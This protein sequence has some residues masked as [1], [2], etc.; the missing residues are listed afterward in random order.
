[1]ERKL[2]VIGR[3][4]IFSVTLFAL[5]VFVAAVN[6]GD[7]L[8][9]LTVV[10]LLGVAWAGGVR[11]I[12]FIFGSESGALDMESFEKYMVGRGKEIPATNRVM[13][14]DNRNLVGAAMSTVR[15]SQTRD[16]NSQDK[17]DRAWVEMT[18]VL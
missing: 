16:T 1:M 11:V 6:N 9:F 10:P 13:G 7:I 3:L 17:E 12:F 15:E 14:E 2:G 18:R 5:L 8:A 4:L